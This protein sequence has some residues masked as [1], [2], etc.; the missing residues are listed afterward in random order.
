VQEKREVKTKVFISSPSQAHLSSGVIV[1]TPA[2]PGP[3]CHHV[4]VTWTSKLG[5]LKSSH[6][7]KPLVTAIFLP[8]SISPP[9]TMTPLYTFLHSLQMNPVPYSTWLTRL[10]PTPEEINWTLGRN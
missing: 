2:L 6:C 9:H 10:R 3:Y 5:M 7:N 1:L 8:G 4:L